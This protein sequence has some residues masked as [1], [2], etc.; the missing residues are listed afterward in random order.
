MT[1]IPEKFVDFSKL[2]LK[3]KVLVVVSSEEEFD[4]VF[5]QFKAIPEYGMILKGVPK[6][7]YYF[8][9]MFRGVLSLLVQEQDNNAR[10][11]QSVLTESLDIWKPEKILMSKLS[12]KLINQISDYVLTQS[13]FQPL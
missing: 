4:D 12:H 6:S 11:L 7:S 10:L 5:P 3:P 2:N 8:M 13:E 1:D 9:G